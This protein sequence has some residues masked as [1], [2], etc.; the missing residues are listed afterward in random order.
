MQIEIVD[1]R[2]SLTLLDIEF[3]EKKE[4]QQQQQSQH[5]A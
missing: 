4:G 1:C 3:Y 2:R 5:H